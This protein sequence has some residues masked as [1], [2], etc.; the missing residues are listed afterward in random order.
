MLVTLVP[1][2]QHLRHAQR[3]LRIPS[4]QLQQLDLAQPAQQDPRQAPQAPL[5]SLLVSAKPDT[6]EQSQAL[7]RLALLALLPT[8][9]TRL[10]QDRQNVPHA[11]NAQHIPQAPTLVVE[12]LSNLANAEPVTSH[13]VTVPNSL[14]VLPLAHLVQVDTMLFPLDQLTAQ[15]VVF[16]TVEMR[17]P[18][19]HAQLQQKH[20]VSVQPVL[21]EQPQ[22]HS[23]R[24]WITSVPPVQR[25]I[26][27]PTA[28][29]QHVQHVLWDT[30]KL[31][32]VK[33]VVQPAQPIPPHP[34]LDRQDQQLAHAPVVSQHLVPHV[35]VL[36]GLTSQMECVHLAQPTTSQPQTVPLHAQHVHQP[37]RL[38]PVQHH[39]KSQS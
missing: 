8:P 4:R 15:P 36:P 12:A 24:T 21:L 17:Q 11:Q 33:L 20:A 19:Q 28:N 38:P 13:L 31:L 22:E 29:F 27:Q 35:C 3:V 6:L 5:L 18:R 10:L 9:S 30:T 26:T 1:S 7:H 14:L 37:T 2:H 23:S 34:P 16:V 25:V 39:A 32:L